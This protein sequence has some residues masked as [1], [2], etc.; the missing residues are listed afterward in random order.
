M[1]F[2]P[3]WGVFVYKCVGGGSEVEYSG[4]YVG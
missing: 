2:T 4:N 3:S 1:C